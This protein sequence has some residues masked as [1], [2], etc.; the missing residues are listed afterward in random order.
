MLLFLVIADSYGSKNLILT[1]NLEFSKWG[2]IFTHK[3]PDATM[4]DYLIHYGHLF[5]FEGQS[6]LTH[7]LMC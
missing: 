6:K 5:T 1:A 4:T 3:Q 7:V 2:G